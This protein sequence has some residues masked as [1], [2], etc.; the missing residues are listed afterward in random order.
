MKQNF[1]ILSKLRFGFI[2]CFGSSSTIPI[3][4]SC[5]SMLNSQTQVSR[6]LTQYFERNCSQ[7]NSLDSCQ[8]RRC[9]IR[10]TKYVTL[11]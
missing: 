6:T 9:R 3:L 11:S 8:N 4:M 5:Q 2:I 1:V 10:S 7:N